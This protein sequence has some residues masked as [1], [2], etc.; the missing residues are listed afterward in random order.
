MPLRRHALA[1]A[2]VL[3]ASVLLVPQVTQARSRQSQTTAARPATAVVL[4]DGSVDPHV[5]AHVLAAV[6]SG[7]WGYTA[8]GKPGLTVYVRAVTDRPLS[9]RAVLATLHI[10]AVGPAPHPP[11]C[12]IFDA[13]CKTKQA[14]VLDAAN[15]A[16]NAARIA[17]TAAART[18]RGLRVPRSRRP[19]LVGATWAAYGLLAM[20]SPGMRY[21]VISSALALPP[22]SP[23]PP[24]LTNID[25]DIIDSCD[26][27]AGT[28]LHRRAQWERALEAGHPIDVRWWDGSADLDIIGD[29]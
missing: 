5:T 18:L 28:C 17:V 16:R 8:Y 10:P 7:M 3:C 24:R 19:D 20:P 25:I 29:S 6:S 27:D 12:S 2:A 21:V 23:G 26:D 22:T 13:A 11:S 1:S 14:A 4:L 9:Y 15:H